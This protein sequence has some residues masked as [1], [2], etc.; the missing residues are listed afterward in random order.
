MTKAKPKHLRPTDLWFRALG[1]I[2][3]EMNGL[4]SE[5]YYELKRTKDNIDMHAYS[6]KRDWNIASG[7]DLKEALGQLRDNG[8]RSSFDKTRWILSSMTEAEQAAYIQTIS[9]ASSQYTQ[10]CIVRAYMNRLPRAGIAAWDWGRYANMC[11]KGVFLS[12]ITE[13][14]ARELLMLIGPEVQK[15]YSGWLEFAISY[16]AG[17]QFW[18]NQLTR[19]S[20]EEHAGYVHKLVTDNKSLWNQLDWKLSLE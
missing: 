16:L 4:D 1:A 20:A 12:Y 17:R 14:E 8:H 5:S 19:E 11:K 2:L 6:L 10:A 9:P 7:E 18:W 13:S 15:A 3:D